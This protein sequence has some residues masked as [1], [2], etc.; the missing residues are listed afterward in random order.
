VIPAFFF[1][2]DLPSNVDDGLVVNTNRRFCPWQR[3]SHHQLLH[4]V[5]VLFNTNRRIAKQE[6]K[7][8]LVNILC[9]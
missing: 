9:L 3:D 8:E 2:T 5:W 6:I 7:D 4:Y 1:K